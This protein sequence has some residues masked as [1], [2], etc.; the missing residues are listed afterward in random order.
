MPTHRCVEL[1]GSQF[2]HEFDIDLI[3]H[4]LSGVIK[5]MNGVSTLPCFHTHLLQL[6]VQA[7]WMIP[8]HQDVQISVILFGLEKKRIPDGMQRY[9]EQVMKNIL[10]MI[11]CVTEFGT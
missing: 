6:F 3:S 8:R 11:E 5:N 1:I 2:T 9:V 4:R 7:I 10:E